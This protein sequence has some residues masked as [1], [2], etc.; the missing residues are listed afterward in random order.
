MNQNNNYIILPLKDDWK[1]LYILLSNFNHVFESENINFIIVNDGSTIN[2][3]YSFFESNFNI[4]IINLSCNIGHQR[5]IAIGLCYIN[6]NFTDVDFISIMDS[7]GEDSPYDLKLLL[8]NTKSLNAIT[9]ANRTNRLENIFF[10]LSYFFYKFIFKSLTGKLISFGNFSSFPS[11][12]LSKLIRDP[13]LWNNY[14]ATMLK[15]N[16]KISLLST[17]KQIR[18]EGKSK[19]NFSKLILHAFSSISVFEDILIS[20]LIIFNVSVLLL[21][22][23]LIIITI[24]IKF[25]TNLA[26]SGW[27]TYTIIS[28]FIILFQVIIFSFFI[29]LFHLLLKNSKVNIPIN[30]Y[31]N[32]IISINKLN[33]HE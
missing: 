22:I 21:L 28:L 25:C 10:K 17:S 9:F 7:D 3:D 18:Y 11:H 27:A 14:P 23:L 13:N 24:I 19:M 8:E 30:V 1:S 20:R 15:L 31:K 26:I 4:T 32:F 2:P 33:I 5:A 16:N 6:D 29:L 12:L